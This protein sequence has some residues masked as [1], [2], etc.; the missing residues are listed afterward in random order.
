MDGEDDGTGIDIGTGTCR[1]TSVGRGVFVTGVAPS[2]FIMAPSSS[3][4]EYG[5]SLVSVFCV[6]EPSMI[7]RQRSPSSGVSTRTVRKGLE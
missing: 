3:G 4:Y 2:P 7:D 5:L 1:G 6:V